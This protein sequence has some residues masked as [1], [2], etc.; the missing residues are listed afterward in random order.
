MRA[1]KQAWTA[2]RQA[3]ART[4]YEEVLDLA[5]VARALGSNLTRVSDAI[6]AAGG[7]VRKPGPPPGSRNPAWVGGR[8]VDKSG[9]VLLRV[10]AHPSRDVAGYVREHRL[11]MEQVL[12]RYLTPEEVVHHR[13]G[14]RAD[15]RP[16]N[17]ECFPS[18]ASH[19]AHELKGRCPNW[20]PDGLA[21]LR[22]SVA[23][24]PKRVPTPTRP[25]S[26][27]PE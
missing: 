7:E 14:D 10:L 19:L 6:R 18:N 20:T 22:A 27:E 4:M 2:A 5:T 16:E 13:N 24:R 1:K 12:G 9:Y 23:R 21:R 3:Q 11:V 8:T 15:N 25:K 26:D 17:L